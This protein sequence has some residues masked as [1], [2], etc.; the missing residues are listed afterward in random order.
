MS[1]SLWRRPNPH[2]SPRYIY[3]IRATF[4]GWYLKQRMLQQKIVAGGK[5]LSPLKNGVMERDLAVVRNMLDRYRQRCTLVSICMMHISAVVW[6]LMYYWMLVIGNRRSG[7]FDERAKTSSRSIQQSTQA[8]CDWC[9]RAPN[10]VQFE[11][12]ADY[13]LHFLVQSL[14]VDVRASREGC[15]NGKDGDHPSAKTTTCLILVAPSPCSK[16]ARMPRETDIF[17][18]PK[19]AAC[20]SN[21]SGP[22]RQYLWSRRMTRPAPPGLLPCEMCCCYHD[23]PG[24]GTLQCLG[25]AAAGRATATINYI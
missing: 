22:S 23:R 10:E 1:H 8:W 12:P 6:R 15:R 16:A 17:D 4:S 20:L 14:S 7:F 21:M 9:R 2:L 3:N 11:L 13:S 5:E 18:L 25:V 24:Y 19:S